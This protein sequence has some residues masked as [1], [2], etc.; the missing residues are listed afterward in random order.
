MRRF[1]SLNSVSAKISLKGKRVLSLLLA[2]MVLVASLGLSAIFAVAENDEYIGAKVTNSFASYAIGS[3]PS[4]ASLTDGAWRPGTTIAT[5][6]IERGSGAHGFDRRFV[7]DSEVAEG[8]GPYNAT[9]MLDLKTD[10][11]IDADTHSFMM[12]IKTPEIGTESNDAWPPRDWSVSFNAIDIVQNQQNGSFSRTAHARNGGFDGWTIDY[13][14]INGTKWESFTM[15]SNGRIKVPSNFEGYLKIDFDN[16]LAFEDWEFSGL[17]TDKEFTVSRLSFVFAWVGAQYGSFDIGGF[18]SITNEADSVMLKLDTDTAPVGM[19]LSANYIEA[20]LSADVSSSE[21]GATPD[22]SLVKITDKE[23]RDGRTAA[24]ATVGEAVTPNFEH[25]S[26]KISAATAEGQ[27]PN[28]ASPCVELNSYTEINANN[29]TLMMYIE[30]PKLADGADWSVRVDG[31]AYN[32]DDNTFWSL[33]DNA[34]Y[35]YLASDGE[36]WAAAKSN[37]SG[38]LILPDGF[39]GYVKLNLASAATW[40]SANKFDRTKN[41]KVSQIRFVFNTL[42]GDYGD[43]VIGGTYSIDRDCAATTMSLDSAEKKS[44]VNY[45]DRIEARLNYDFSGATVGSAVDTSSSGIFQLK[46]A[47]YREG[48]TQST[49]VYGEKISVLT[50]NKPIVLNSNVAEGEGPNN[51]TPYV[52]FWPWTKVSAQA[53]TIILFIEAPKFSE[54]KAPQWSLRINGLS[55][56]QDGLNE[57]FFSL[58]D[59]AEY[60]YLDAD[61]KAWVDG[62]SDAQGTLFLPSGFK[63]YLKLYLDTVTMGYKSENF[64]RTKDYMVNSI[65]FTFG[66]LGGEWGAFKISD[67]FEVTKESKSTKIKLNGGAI[68]EMTNYK[69]NNEAMVKEFKDIVNNIGTIDINDAAA[70]DRAAYILET[71]DK[72]YAAQIG[73]E[74]MKG[75]KDA[76]QA[77]GTYR[78]QL[79]GATI[80]APGADVQA[81]KLGATV[82][83]AAAEKDGYTLV[84]YGAVFVYESDYEGGIL[85]ENTANAVKISGVK[86]ETAGTVTKYNSVLDVPDAA[87]YGKQ[88]LVRTYVTYKASDSNETITLWNGN[89]V[90]SD[91]HEETNFKCSLMDIA[92]YFGVA[93]LGE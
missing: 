82:D 27:A 79:M 59:N 12:Y 85:N 88:L 42:G 46:D 50:N 36:A 74:A 71:L 8:Q 31:L 22:T 15:D 90:Y 89:Y 68:A 38:D 41:Y 92:S 87:S 61:G 35:Y 26:I 51:A 25:K 63:G 30:T 48:T 37:A 62:K 6:K 58:F 16:A 28:N 4:F 45:V 70:L 67:V 3:V 57:W 47:G 69:A 44:M 39:K 64:D 55:Y 17:E 24:T 23:W 56:Q 10:I 83:A 76:S 40:Y 72:E 20:K 78:P 93:V 33:F 19:V 2:V 65:D 32:Q 75:Y 77:I 9:P 81:I 54:T 53:N 14:D 86:S 84:D 43:F 21:V 18:Y 91:G 13:L 52:S 80:K 5:S 11:T 60:S 29:H 73:D 1:K 34:D 7:F 66:W 49:A